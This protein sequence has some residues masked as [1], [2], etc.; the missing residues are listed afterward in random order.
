MLLMILDLRGVPLREMI[1]KNQNEVQLCDASLRKET[2][3]NKTYFNSLLSSGLTEDG[4]SSQLEA[5]RRPK[6]VVA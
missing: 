3:S 1:R 6:F 5:D 2:V 4:L